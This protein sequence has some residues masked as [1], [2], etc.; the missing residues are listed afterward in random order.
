MFAVHHELLSG[1]KIIDSPWIT[2]WIEFGK[3]NNLLAEN[4]N[5][6]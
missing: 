2:T 3:D 1:Q 6:Y 4:E 5:P